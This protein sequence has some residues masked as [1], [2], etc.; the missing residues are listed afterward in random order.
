M[1]ESDGLDRTT[2]ERVPLIQLIQSGVQLGDNCL[3]LIGDDNQFD[4][5]LFV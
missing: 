3:G 2:E 4:I 5:D 1:L